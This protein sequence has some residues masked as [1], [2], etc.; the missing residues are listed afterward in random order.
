M[1]SPTHILY[2]SHT[3]TGYIAPVWPTTLNLSP[4]HPLQ[5][6]T[7]VS[8]AYEN[9]Q[10]PLK[11]ATPVF[12]WTHNETTLTANEESGNETTRFTINEMSLYINET[13]LQ[14]TGEY[15]LQVSRL[16]LLEADQERVKRFVFRLDAGFFCSHLIFEALQLYAIFKP[17]MFSIQPGI[18]K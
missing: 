13:E 12:L 17:V 16:T 1:H 8:Q 3:S 15:R 18:V 6:E 5:L 14:D 10:G 11:S 9:N 7:E 2:T 4:P